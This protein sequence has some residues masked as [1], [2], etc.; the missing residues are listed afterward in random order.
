[1]EIRIA[2]VLLMTLFMP[3]TVVSF[4][5]FRLKKKEEEY[6][7]MMYTMGV[8]GE[9]AAW[10]VQAVRDDYAPADYILPVAF[11][12]VV[13]FLGSF[14]LLMGGELYVSPSYNLLLVGVNFPILDPPL[15]PFQH[16]YLQSMLV[17]AVA[18]CGAFMWSTQN[19]IR[20]LITADLTP[21]TYYRAGLRIMFSALV[22][23]MLSFFLEAFPTRQYSHSILPVIAFLT[24]MFPQQMLYYLKERVRKILGQKD[25]RSHELSLDMIEGINAFHMVRLGEEGI[26]NGQN[27]AEANV[28]DLL[29]RTPFNA[30]QLI[31]W[32]AQAKLYVYFKSDIDKLRRAG[33][34]TVFDFRLACSQKKQIEQL[35]AE[36]GLSALA[37][38]LVYQVVKNDEAV[39]NLRR[40]Q[41]QLC[42]IDGRPAHHDYQE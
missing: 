28:T 34:R 3:L 35:A 8:G 27:L 26:D 42:K 16:L 31:D 5:R 41:A 24:G 39:A 17:L 29:R 15:L 12:T 10:A 2:L 19:I 33:V 6:R 32:I 20:R 13:S 1:M 23:L 36:T 37:L 21:G 7:Q 18:F 14:T 11:V 25:E 38:T 4:F 22:A 9:D 30:T 40:G